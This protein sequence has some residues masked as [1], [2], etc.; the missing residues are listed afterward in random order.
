VAQL[1][2]TVTAAAP[3]PGPPDPVLPGDAEPARSPLERVALAGIALLLAAVF[4][5]LG[6]AAFLGGEV[7]LGVM[8]GIGALMTVWA[9]ASNLRRG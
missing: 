4:G 7:F 5:G 6:V 8:G 3:D 1:G 2:E 9:A